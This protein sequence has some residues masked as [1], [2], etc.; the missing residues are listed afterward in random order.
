MGVALKG[1]VMF[2][3]VMTGELGSAEPLANSKNESDMDPFFK[4]P[5][6]KVELN[7]GTPTTTNTAPEED[8]SEEL[9]EVK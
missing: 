9:D 5:E 8:R 2:G 1:K 3:S 4:E 7:A 6:P